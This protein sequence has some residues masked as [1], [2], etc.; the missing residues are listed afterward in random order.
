MNKRLL[1]SI[2]FIAIVAVCL[3]LYSQCKP[4]DSDYLYVTFRCFDKQRCGKGALRFLKEETKDFDKG[5]TNYDEW[6][7]RVTSFPHRYLS[8][9]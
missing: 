8:S 1:I 5:D 2:P 3:F 7:A 9:A 6:L 4:S